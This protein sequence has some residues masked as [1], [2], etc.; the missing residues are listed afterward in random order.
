[1]RTI[2][3]EQVNA[4]R[5]QNVLKL[6]YRHQKIITKK[7]SNRKAIIY[8]ITTLDCLEKLKRKID[9]MK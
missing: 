4:Q 7:N 3:Y 1:M 8:V 9:G 2:R 6:S 5:I